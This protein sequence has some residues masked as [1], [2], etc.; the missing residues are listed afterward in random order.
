MTNQK[1]NTP[2][3]RIL[4]H[5]YKRNL[6]KQFGK[7]NGSTIYKFF[8]K[9]Y[10]ELFSNRTVFSNC[11]LNKHLTKNIL[12]A[13]ALYDAL[14]HRGL[15]KEEALDSIEC[16]YKIVYKKT[17]FMYSLLGRIPFFFQLL[18]KLTTRSM[19]VTY[20]KEGWTT[21]W[22]ENSN[23]QISFDV[24][25]CFYQDILKSYEREELLKC[26]CQIDDDVYDRISPHVTWKRT[27][28]LGRC[29]SKCDFR[30]I[31]K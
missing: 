28:T 15:S 14:L 18:R 23:K 8:F 3:S 26:F 2:V 4:Y 24:N 12:P 13:I 21:V 20:P 16:F 19:S 17:A 5:S 9:K 10:E 25:K 27:T 22:I 29:G 30:F 31:K 6:N 7:E 11:I 1:R